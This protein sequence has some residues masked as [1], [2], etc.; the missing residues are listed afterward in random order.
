MPFQ[1]V[2]SNISAAPLARGFA[3]RQSGLLTRNKSF[4]PLQWGFLL[5][6]EVLDTEQALT[7]RSLPLAKCRG[8]SHY[9]LVIMH[10]SLKLINAA[11]YSI[12]LGMPK[13]LGTSLL[14]LSTELQV[15][16][17]LLVMP[18]KEIFTTYNKNSLHH[19]TL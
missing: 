13:T 9:L 10:C 11:A 4:L 7:L 5:R 3:E 19:Y 8:L 1:P 17:K 14:E 18:Y 15:T 2:N 12:G 6:A 16:S